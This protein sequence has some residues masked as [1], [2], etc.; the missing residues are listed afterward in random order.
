MNAITRSV[1]SLT[2]AAALTMPLIPAGAAAQNQDKA[3]VHIGSPQVWSLG[4]AHYLLAKLHQDDRGLG[5]RM[6]EKE[7]LDPNAINATKI[8]M[9][10]SLLDIEAQFSQKSGVE[11]SAAQREEQLKLRQRSDA[12]A[13]LPAK[14][15]ELQ[16]LDKQILDE[17]QRLVALFDRFAE[18]MQRHLERQP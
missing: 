2:L 6:P 13:A 5:T 3:I 10:Q 18:Q 16:A 17:Q 1:F 4:Q 14:Q 11:N 7:D 15:K 12:Q 9:I 8:Q